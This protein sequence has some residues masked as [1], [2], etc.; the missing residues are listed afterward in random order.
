MIGAKPFGCVHVV[1]AG[2]AAYANLFCQFNVEYITGQ[3]GPTW[4]PFVY[5]PWHVRLMAMYA[6]VL[7]A[8]SVPKRGIPVWLYALWRP[9]DA[10]GL[11]SVVQGAQGKA[12]WQGDLMCEHGFGVMV[13]LPSVIAGDIITI[14]G[15]YEPIR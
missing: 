12:Q 1:T 9:S 11:A 13:R 14:G 5:K 3:W 4:E 15:S 8:A 7:N 2:E 10:Y 6:E